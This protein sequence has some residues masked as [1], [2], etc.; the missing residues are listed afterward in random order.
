MTFSQ[1]WSLVDV[2]RGFSPYWQAIFPRW[3]RIDG[4]QNP[5]PIVWRHRIGSGKSRR[6]NHISPKFC[7]PENPDPSLGLR[8]PGPSIGMDQGNPLGHSNGSLEFCNQHQGLE[9]FVG[10]TT[11]QEVPL[12][13]SRESY[14]IGPENT[15]GPPINGRKYMGNRSY[16]HYK[17]SYGPLLIADFPG[18]KGPSLEVILDGFW[19]SK[20]I[21]GM[22]SCPVR[23]RLALLSRHET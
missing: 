19:S 15:W 21:A 11:W 13:K 2:C 6:S 17:R 23:W 12:L 16:N 7:Y 10:W 1:Y 3:S 4:G 8:N 22:N 14:N 20:I 9:P 5:I 18:R